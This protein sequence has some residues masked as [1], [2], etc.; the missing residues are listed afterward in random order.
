MTDGTD[1]TRA[2]FSEIQRQLAQIIERDEHREQKRDAQLD[3]LLTTL[4]SHIQDDEHRLTALE[5]SR[6]LLGMWGV[7]V[8]VALG[9]LGIKLPGGG[10][11]Q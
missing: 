6:N 9:A 2:Q 7:V 5:T 10:G 4:G 3:K 1:G 8:T 11:N